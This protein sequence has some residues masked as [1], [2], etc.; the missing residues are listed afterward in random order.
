MRGNLKYLTFLTRLSKLLFEILIVIISTMIMTILVTSRGNAASADSEDTRFYRCTGPAAGVQCEAAETKFNSRGA[1]GHTLRIFTVNLTEFKPVEGVFGDS[2]KIYGYKQQYFTM[3]DRHFINPP[4]FSVSFWIKQD[5]GYTANS[6]IISHI[7]S[8]K[9]AGWYIQSNAKNLDSRIQFSVA[10]SNGKIFSATAPLDTDVFQNI[11]GIFDGNAVKI[12]SN[13]FLVDKVAFSG[14]YNPDPD[15]PLNIGLNSYDYRQVWNGAIDEV[16]LYDKVISDD[17]I[18]G[19]ADYGKYLQ[20]SSSLVDEHVVGYW[21]FDDGLL[22]DKSENHN[23]GKII[24]PSA[25]MVSSPDGRLF[26]SVRDAGEIRIMN[27]DGTFLGEPF[28]RLEANATNESQEILGITL[29]PDFPTNHFVYAL[30]RLEDSA[31]GIVLSRIIRFTELNDVATDQKI[32]LDNIPAASGRRLA[33]ALAFGPD[34]KLYVATSY[35]TQIEKSQNA[36]LSGKV[37]RINRDGTI[38]QDNPFS[39]SAIYTQGHSNIFALAFDKTTGTGIVTENNPSRND[40]INVLRKGENYDSPAM[41]QQSLKAGVPKMGNISAIEPVR[42]YHKAMMPTQALF[43]DDNKFPSL[44]GKF[45]VVSYAETAL[46]GLAFNSTGNLIE[47]VTI[48]LPEVLGHIASIA[49]APNGDLFLGGEN[50]YKLVSIDNSRETPTYF[51]EVNSKN[52]QIKDLSVNLTRK[53]ISIDFMNNNNNVNQGN[54]TGTS[55]L[56]IKVPKILIGTIYDVTSEKYNNTASSADKIVDNF[57]TKETR[58][59]SNVGD[60]IIDV[61]LKE[62]VGNDKIFIKGKSSGLILPP[63]NRIIYR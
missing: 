7:N 14:D 56:H 41:E 53:V 63:K 38:P 27:K 6:S 1:T 47:E 33:G 15:V 50:I 8:S 23:D 18:Q 43:Y 12:Y 62:I 60:T 4:V 35:T 10:N 11:V 16:R 45:L 36:N 21:P 34:D 2:L 58:R 48:R 26:Y 30:A 28:V 51:I 3:P 17:E 32:L 52:I 54:I 37:L 40:E 59:V 22:V 49:K 29:D 13:G 31:T 57:K 46:Y 44:K 9:T 20:S 25:S 61:Q 55:V 19:L 5:R 39:N 24:L 42:T